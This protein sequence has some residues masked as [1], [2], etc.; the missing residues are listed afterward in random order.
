[1]IV[2]FIDALSE[3]PVFHI[4]GPDFQMDPLPN[5]IVVDM[6]GHQ[7]VVLRRAWA[8]NRAAVPAGQVLHIGAEKVIAVDL[9]C[10]VAPAAHLFEYLDQLGMLPPG[11]SNGGGTSA[12]S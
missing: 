12:R 1:M 4:G 3:K 6:D 5:D 8:C 10:T 2:T 7:Y 11:T 9:Q